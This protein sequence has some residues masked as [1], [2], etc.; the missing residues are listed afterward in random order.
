M[1]LICLF[2]P[3][4]AIIAIRVLLLASS[5]W[6]Y[7]K[8][9]QIEKDEGVVESKREFFFGLFERSCLLEIILFLKVEKGHMIDQNKGS[10]LTGNWAHFCY[11]V[12]V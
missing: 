4:L 12:F 8:V 11:I 3:G 2:S 10:E 7:H 9:D 6:T 1:Y 5:S